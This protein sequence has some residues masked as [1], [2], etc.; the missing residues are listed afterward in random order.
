MINIKRVLL[1]LY[2][3]TSAIV[4]SYA[5]DSYTIFGL[6]KDNLT[7]ETLADVHVYIFSDTVLIDEGIT[8]LKNCITGDGEHGLWYGDIP[9]QGGTFRFVFKKEGYEDVERTEVIKPFKKS[10]HIRFAFYTYMQRKKKDYTLGEA[11]VMATQVKF[12]YKG[13]TVVYNADAFNLAEGSMLDNL[14]RQLPGAEL[15]DNGEITLDG[16]HVKALLLNGEDFF[17]GKNKVM[18]ENLPAYMVKNVQAYEKV[19]DKDKTLG[20]KHGDFILDVN[21][22]R[23]YTLN[24]L[25]NIEAGAGSESR[26]LARL[27]AMRLTKASRLT[28]YGNLNNLNDARKP[29]ENSSWTPETMPTGMLSQKAGGFDYLVKPQKSTFKFNGNID[30]RYQDADNYTETTRENFLSG[31]N[32]FMRSS[33]NS[34]N[35]NL[36]LSTSHKLKFTGSDEITGVEINPSLSYR[37]YNLRS[38]SIGATFAA[39]PFTY[40]DSRSLLDS[41]QTLQGD[42]LRRLMLN[43]YLQSKK[44]DGWNTNANLFIFPAKRI[45]RGFIALPIYVNYFAAKDNTFSQYGIKYP[46]QTSPQSDVFQNTYTHQK[47]NTMFRYFIRPLFSKNLGGMGGNSNYIKIFPEIGQGIKQQNN[48]RYD[49]AIL[50]EWGD[51]TDYVVAELPSTIDYKLQTL[52][53]QNSYRLHEYDNYQ[54]ITTEYEYYYEPEEATDHQC[55]ISLWA[56]LKA[57]RHHY[58]L[59]YSRGAYSGITRYTTVLFNPQLEVKYTWDEN[60]KKLEME[61]ELSQTSPDMVSFVDVENNTDPLN[62]YYGNPDLENK[63]THNLSFSYTGNST[64][65]QTAFSSKLTCHASVNDIAYA[66]TYDHNTGVRHYRPQNINGNYWLYS[67]ATYS[68]PLDK[69]RHLTLYNSTTANYDHGVDF[70]S[71]DAAVTPMRSNVNRWRGTETLRLT[72]KLGKH[73]LGLKGSI[74]GSHVTSSRSDFESFSVCSFNYGLTALVK[75]PLNIELSTDLTMY[76]RRGY[77][78]GSSNANDLVWNGRLTKSFPKLGLTFMLDGFDIL[79]QLSNVTTVINSQ[80]RTET[81][82][83]SLPR[84]FMA[85]VIYR[86]SKKQGRNKH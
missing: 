48:N 49:L 50:P 82:R 21:L 30:I 67:Y 43:R 72:Y 32:T 59:D 66:Y 65:R 61:Y 57:T 35:D 40:T 78:T 73:T 20:K 80:G 10:M 3:M 37:H 45:G 39:D 29:G 77:A 6:V 56:S 63:T 76:S 15:S 74:D 24:S 75:L 17:K 69:A 38:G 52:D 55:E 58:R 2:I 8:D 13:D 19:D 5:D 11:T 53:L 33:A 26:Y 83:N 25:G 86:L 1:S 84:Y 68:T 23:Q 47:P 27:F 62:I 81:Y 16:K 28:L 41:I 18:L 9:Q 7:L 46:N 22:K 85:H 79:N 12:Y 54:G 4:M 42:N 31:G 51:G 70:I 60:R 14:I 36:N 71:E 44:A 34:S 64:K